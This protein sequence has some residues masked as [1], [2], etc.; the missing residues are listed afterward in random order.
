MQIPNPFECIFLSVLN[1]F[2]K[3]MS[4][5]ISIDIIIYYFN[6]SSI[7]LLF[8]FSI[9]DISTFDGALNGLNLTLWNKFSWINEHR[10]TSQIF[11]YTFRFVTSESAALTFC[12]FN[13]VFR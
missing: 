5:D 7:C 1:I 11:P 2:Y 8:E 4:I 13:M 10:I 6:T 9:F 3:K 12:M